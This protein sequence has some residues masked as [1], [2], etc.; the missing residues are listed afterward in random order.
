MSEPTT[1]AELKAAQERE[2]GTYVAKQA[3]YI[4]RVRAFNPG[5]PVPV[6]HVK[7]GVVS[8]DQVTEKN[9]KAPAANESKG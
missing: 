2:Y 4:G 6:G 3:I 7:R 9:T 5:D 8:K 1:V